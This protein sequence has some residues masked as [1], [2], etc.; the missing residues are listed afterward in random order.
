MSLLLFLRKESGRGMHK[1]SLI[2]ENEVSIQQL[3]V[4]SHLLKDGRPGIFHCESVEEVRDIIEIAIAGGWVIHL[5]KRKEMAPWPKADVVYSP[6]L[7][8]IRHERMFYGATVIIACIGD[9]PTA[10]MR[11]VRNHAS[12]LAKEVQLIGAGGSV[13]YG[14][15]PGKSTA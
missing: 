13:T 12:G 3:S 10:Y 4:I 6:L 15:M 9:E 1:V 7:R 14:F 5:W 2:I 8:G 11:E